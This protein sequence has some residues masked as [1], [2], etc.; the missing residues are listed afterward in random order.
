M[1]I[2]GILMALYYVVAFVFG[3]IPNLPVMPPS[4][5]GFGDFVIDMAAG[6]AGVLV[7]I[8]T[9][10]LFGVI[11]GMSLALLFFN[12]GYYIVMFIARKLRIIH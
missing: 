7:H 11:I 6:A 3:V 1:I 9:A 5:V 8:Y 2:Q 12:Q 10:P 4:I